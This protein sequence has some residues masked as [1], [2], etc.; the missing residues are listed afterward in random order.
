M[1]KFILD[2]FL[3][4][5][6]QIF[7]NLFSGMAACPTDKKCRQ[8]SEVYGNATNFCQKVWDQ[9]WKVVD[10]D[11]P[12]GCFLMTW[13]EGAD[14]PNY[15]VAYNK[16]SK[17]VNVNSCSRITP[18]IFQSIVFMLIVILIGFCC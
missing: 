12:E 6:H 2:L 4:S 3:A 5:V 13:Q 14:N 18:N 1:F 9:S 11:H 8:F 17:I 16:A 15:K 7:F 10:D